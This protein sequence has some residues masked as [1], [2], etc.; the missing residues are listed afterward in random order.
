MLKDVFPKY[1]DIASEIKANASRRYRDYIMKPI[2]D[3]FNVDMMLKNK[4]STYKKMY[5]E[6]K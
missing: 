2:N 3:E 4:R 1:P 6:E 5:F